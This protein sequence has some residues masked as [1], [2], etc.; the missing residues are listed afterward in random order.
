MQLFEVE[1]TTSATM[2]VLAEDED[3]ARKIAEREADDSLFFG[4]NLQIEGVD[5][6]S[7]LEG[8]GGAFRG[9]SIY[10]EDNHELTVQRYFEGLDV[11]EEPA[12][13]QAELERAGQ[14]RLL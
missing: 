5:P 4:A 12:I 2:Y 7:S 8:V 11:G 6:V 1:V 9:E 14:R 3:A 10:S 13:T